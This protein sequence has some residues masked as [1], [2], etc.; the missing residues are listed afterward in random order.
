[1]HAEESQAGIWVEVVRFIHPPKPAEPALDGHLHDAEQ[2]QESEQVAGAASVPP[3]DVALD[4]EQVPSFV[5]QAQRRAWWNKP[6]VRFVLGMLLVF[7]P[8]ALVLQIAVHERN[9]LA[10]WK[11]QWRDGLQNMCVLLRCEITP[12][13]DI[14]AVV[15]TGSAFAQDALPNHYKLDLSMQNQAALSVAT[16]AVE[17]T[18]TDAQGQ[19]LVRKVL[20]PTEIGAPAELAGRGEW[21]GTLP[22]KTQGLNLPVS[23]YRVTAFYP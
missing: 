16:P 12:Y 21:N 11:P 19:V 18:L 4:A 6:G 10:A 23:G 3:V 1:M 22:V 9:R 17:L 14:H 2:T 20:Q 8:L 5:K 15:L 7:L 13:R